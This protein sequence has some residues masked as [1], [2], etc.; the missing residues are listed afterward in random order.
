RPPDLFGEH[1]RRAAPRESVDTT[2][3]EFLLRIIKGLGQPEGRVGKVE[4]AVRREDEVVGT[5]QP[6]A[7]VTVHQRGLTAIFFHPRDA[8]V[9][10][11][12]EDEAAGGIEGE[13]VRA[14]LPALK[15]GRGGVD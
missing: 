10:V 6:L 7:L 9:A 13:A 2:E 12:T 8:A 15:L 14:G 3:I 5:V 4:V 11:L 1:R